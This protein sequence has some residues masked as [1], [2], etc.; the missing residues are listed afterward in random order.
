VSSV[1]SILWGT[2]KT[3]RT[4]QAASAAPTFEANPGSAAGSEATTVRGAFRVRKNTAGTAD[5][6]T[7][8]FEALPNGSVNVP[9]ALSAG[10][11]TYNY[12]IQTTNIPPPS[13]ATAY[14]IKVGTFNYSLGAKLFIRE[15]GNGIEG[16]FYI[17]MM[18]GY[19]ATRQIIAEYGKHDAGVG[20]TALLLVAPD[21]N[22]SWNAAME[23][24]LKAVANVSS[25]SYFVVY[26]S[27]ILYGSFEPAA[28]N[29]QSAAPANIIQALSITG[30]GG[31]ATGGTACF[32]SMEVAKTTA[33]TSPTTGALA[34]AG[35]AGVAGNLNVGGVIWAG[36]G[37]GVT[38]ALSVS[39][40]AT[41]GNI[42]QAG[43]TANGSFVR[44]Y[45]G[46][47]YFY[48]GG[49]MKAKMKLAA[50]AGM[51]SLMASGLPFSCEGITSNGDIKGETVDPAAAWT[52]VSIPTFENTHI[53][54]IAYGAGKFVAT[55]SNG[56][57]AYSTDGVSWTV[58]STT[59]TS[60]NYIY[61]IAYGAGKFIAAGGGGKMAYSTD[62]V[63]W[64]AVSDPK[65]GTTAIRAI[66]YGAGK[67]VAVGESGKAAYSAD[68]V[69]WTAVSD[70]KFGTGSVIYAIAYSDG[71]FVAAGHYGKIAY[72]A[73]STARLIFKPDGTVGWA[74][75]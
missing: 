70:P 40:D 66:T 6:E 1:S 61:A 74:K 53:Y 43:K 21:G 38:G 72:W 35:G 36:D 39:N 41:I 31:I 28:A 4:G 22:T 23:L 25:T 42:L 56:R 16:K 3:L 59:D 9:G 63:S 37:L 15:A 27:D 55:G 12:P 73:A 51:L 14:Y 60:G 46:I 29:Y 54:A 34:V 18:S 13:A 47:L 71:K 17:D 2:F 64:T 7:A 10:K 57:A 50:V 58:V 62:G 20:I 8:V 49:V 19:S 69:S 67:F 5:G 75:E 32:G 24:W 65:F 33:S 44:F 52:A 26:L 30:H 48:Q 68:G 11:R 45:N